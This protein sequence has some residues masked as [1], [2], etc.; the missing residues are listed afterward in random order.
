MAMIGEAMFQPN[1]DDALACPCGCESPHLT[2][3]K[4]TLDRR[5]GRLLDLELELSCGITGEVAMLALFEHEGQ[6][7]LRWL[8][9]SQ[10]SR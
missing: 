1:W 3:G 9:S 6:V 5:S 7:H 8:N 10:G 2:P 4:V